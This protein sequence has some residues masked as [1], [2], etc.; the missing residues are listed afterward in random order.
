MSA[1]WQYFTI[2]LSP[3]VLIDLPVMRT[4]LFLSLLVVGAA[5]AHGQPTREPVIEHQDECIDP[6]VESMYFHFVEGGAVQAESGQSLVLRDKSGKTFQIDLV[7]LEIADD[8][9]AAREALA[10]LVQGKS[11]TVLY[12]PEFQK[13]D[14]LLG[15][16][17]L[18]DDYL[19]VSRLLLQAGVVRYKEPPAYSVSGYSSCLY[20]IAEREAKQAGLG[21]W[22]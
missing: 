18:G 17:Q 7:G 2:G 9:A 21:L 6:R 13:G 10:R 3:A 15:Q 8:G 1:R 4:I 11:L 22:K 20:R 16:A 19:D 14:R 5:S 12:N